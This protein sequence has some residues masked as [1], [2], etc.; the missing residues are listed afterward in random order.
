MNEIR[1]PLLSIIVP[2]KNREKYALSVTKQIL[3]F[4]YNNFELI[5]QNNSDT[6]EL[7]YMLS[8]YKNDKRLKYNYHGGILSTIGNF[9]QA[10][11]LCDGEY[12]CAI[13]DDDGINPEIIKVVEWAKQNNVDAIKPGLQF[14]YLWPESGTSINKE[15][16]DNGSI[17]ISEITC[18][19]KI[20]NTKIELDKLMA[21]GC[22]NY[23]L[24]DLVKVYHGVVKRE[25]MEQIKEITGSYF[26]G[27]AP[28]IYSCIALSLLIKK[29][30]SIDYPLT[31]AGACNKS[32]S[33]DS[34]TGRHTGKLEDAPHFTGHYNY[35]WAIEVPRF[36]SVETIWAD[37]G[38]A[39]IKDMNLIQ[40]DLLSH[41]E[42]AALTARCLNSSPQYSKEIM[43]HYYNYSSS[44]GINKAKAIYKLGTYIFKTYIFKCINFAKN[45]ITNKTKTKLINNV[46]DIVEAEKITTAYLNDN[47]IN[48]N[49]VIN[50]LNA[51]YK[52]NT[53]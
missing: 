31:I 47:N 14:F 35:E 2:S 51:C 5:V 3:S 53:K 52:S 28:D 8:E 22:Q 1:E 49:K 26:G 19:V 27:L 46:S 24:R 4:P 12:V 13:G 44:I 39:S 48:I 11:E 40:K 21:D 20:S 17:L 42:C 43:G 25:Y 29:V 16:I 18:K 37:S 30:V 33:A 36:Y 9:S 38:L 34:A 23:L 45:K 41:F 32:S 15:N 7:E 50:N 10:M 6:N